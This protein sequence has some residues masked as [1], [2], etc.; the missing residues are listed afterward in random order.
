MWLIA[1]DGAPGS[2]PTPIGAAPLIVGRDPTCGLVLDDGSASRRHASFTLLAPGQVEVRDLGS[3]NGVQ[4]NG[5][6][7]T[8]PVVLRGG[9][10]VRIGDAR[11]AVDV[12][13]AGAAATVIEPSAALRPPPAPVPAPVPAAPPTPPPVPAPP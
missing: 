3:T 8:A 7:I 5:A 2:A 6:R 4:V 12:A 11:F 1:L 13:P 10:E 9:E